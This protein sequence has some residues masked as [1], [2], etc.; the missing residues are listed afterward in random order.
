MVFEK[1]TTFFIIII[2]A[3]KVFPTIYYYLFL[4]T[5]HLNFLQSFFI[6]K[7]FIIIKS[8]LLAG[9]EMQVTLFKKKKKIGRE[10]KKEE[11]EETAGGERAK[12]RI[13]IIH[14][15]N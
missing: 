1:N 12:E 8:H 10:K 5:G 15:Y 6:S 4:K 9:P 14:E 7:Y 13:E 11:E 2:I 3:G